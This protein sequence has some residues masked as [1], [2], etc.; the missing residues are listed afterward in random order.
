LSA[1]DVCG[2]ALSP[3]LSH[4]S[5][6]DAGVDIWSGVL[7]RNDATENCDQL[8][9]CSSRSRCRSYDASS[10]SSSVPPSP[11]SPEQLETNHRR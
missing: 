2:G 4:S 9:D 8:G 6:Q 7:C 11:P 1:S 10:S 3:P 5:H